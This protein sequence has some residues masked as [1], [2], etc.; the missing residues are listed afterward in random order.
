MT[1]V[2]IFLAILAVIKVVK[3]LIKKSDE[4]W[5]REEAM[6]VA[7]NKVARDAS[8]IVKPSVK[9]QAVLPELIHEEKKVEVLAD[10]DY[11][12][13][14]HYAMEWLY[15]DDDDNDDDDDDDDED[16]LFG[17]IDGLDDIEDETNDYLKY[18]G[19]PDFTDTEVGLHV[20]MEV[21]DDDWSL[22]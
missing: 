1:E 19:V 9:E 22:W 20:G 7:T 8:R 4:I 17:D 5:L 12:G 3:S 15:D 18:T 2:L 14:L 21:L 16:D 10:N 11:E 13:E 6:R